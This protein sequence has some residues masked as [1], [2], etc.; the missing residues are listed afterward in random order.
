MLAYVGITTDKHTQYEQYE[1]T[2]RLPVGDLSEQILTLVTYVH[3]L[4]IGTPDTIH[5]VTQIDLI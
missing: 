5:G 2:L 4:I 3:S 1:T